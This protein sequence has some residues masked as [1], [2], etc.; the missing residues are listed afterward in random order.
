MDGRDIPQI[1]CLM[2]KWFIR[3]A[4]KWPNMNSS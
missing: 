1:L 3:D 4:K 2:K